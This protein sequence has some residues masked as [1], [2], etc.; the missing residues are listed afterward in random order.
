MSKE[1]FFQKLVRYIRGRYPTEV[2]ALLPAAGRGIHDEKLNWQILA[3][4]SAEIHETVDGKIGMWSARTVA[5]EDTI[6]SH[7]LEIDS[8]KDHRLRF[9]KT[10]QIQKELS[11]K[12]NWPKYRSKFEV[13]LDRLQWGEEIARDISEKTGIEVK[14]YIPKPPSDN[15]LFYSEFD[16]KGLSDE[17]KTNEIKRHLDAIDEA[18]RKFQ[19]YD[20]R[21]FEE[22]F[23]KK[24]DSSADKPSS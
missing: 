2:Q 11:D 23:S 14:H 9:D 16:S 13:I 4:R 5:V 7:L 22:K 20:R 24:R 1:Q 15:A 18:H 21:W 3:V 17:E 10:M 19:E 6:S 8:V 12:N